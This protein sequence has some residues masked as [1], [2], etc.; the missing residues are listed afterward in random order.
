[1]TTSPSL[2]ARAPGWYDDPYNPDQPRY[3]DGRQFRR[4]GA[5]VPGSGVGREPVGVRAE[6]TAGDPRSGWPPPPAP[7]AP[8]SSAPPG[9]PSAEVAAPSVWRKS[10]AWWLLALVLLAVLA[11]GTACSLVVANA[12]ASPIVATS[13]L[14]PA[15]PLGTGALIIW[16]NLEP[17]WAASLDPPAHPVPPRPGW[18]PLSTDPQRLGWWSGTSFSYWLPTP[19]QGPVPTAG[20]RR[21]PYTSAGRPA[22]G[23][24]AALFLAVALTSGTCLGFAAAAFDTGDVRP[25]ARWALATIALAVAALPAHRRLRWRLAP[26]RDGVID[27]LHLLGTVMVIGSVAVPPVLFAM[28]TML[29]GL[30]AGL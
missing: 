25:G 12:A 23:W 6:D 24:A 7:P 1:M 27:S 16:L 18:Y 17:A 8:P 4:P 26:A 15:I 19:T 13:V 10:S 11:A 22:R 21:W 9:P 3:W 20:P 14:G 29:N 30:A 2:H 5:P 28:A